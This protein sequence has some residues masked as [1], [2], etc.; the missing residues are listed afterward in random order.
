LPA[1]FMA[2]ATGGTN[3]GG[4]RNLP[5]SAIESVKMEDSTAPHDLVPVELTILGARIRGEAKVPAA[6]VALEELLPVFRMVTDAVVKI[7]VKAVEQHG[8]SISCC[9]GC[10]ACCR[11]PVPVS[12]PEARRLAALVEAMPEPRR[13][14]VR[15]VFVEIERRVDEAG[16]MGAF[17][18]PDP[19]VK[20]EF[21][22]AP[23]EYF[24][25][26]MGCPFLVED[27]CGI[28]EERPLVCREYL[29][30][31]PAAYCSAPDERVEVLRMPLKASEA[32]AR[33]EGTEGKRYVKQIPLGLSLKWCRENAAPIEERRAAAVVTEFIG[34][35]E[36]TRAT[37]GPG[38]RSEV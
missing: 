34:H 37:G 14:D 1:C 8:K 21:E 3:F 11:Q 25:M 12:L 35:L 18:D 5:E 19:M 9:K 36:R 10:G 4:N 2:L 31:S 15:A 17:L 22:R 28:Y 30:T 26:G 7:S 23:M 16:L 24:R 6:A 29:V 20:E 32:L 13:S 33:L 38:T 27:S